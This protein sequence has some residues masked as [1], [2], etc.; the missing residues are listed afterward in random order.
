MKLVSDRSNQDPTKIKNYCPNVRSLWSGIRH[1]AYPISVI[2][3]A[4]HQGDQTDSN[5]V[6]EKTVLTYAN[7]F[8]AHADEFPDAGAIACGHVEVT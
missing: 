7:I 6:G 8:E 5:P 1:F 2:P 4:P 3:F